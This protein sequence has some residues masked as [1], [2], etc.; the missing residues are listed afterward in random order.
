MGR[1]LDSFDRFDWASLLAGRDILLC[2][3]RHAE[4][5][6]I[7]EGLE[8]AGARVTI[9]EDE[10]QA[11]DRLERRQFVIAILA[12]DG[13]P[14]PR[15][16]AAIQEKGARLVM[17]AQV[18]RHAALRADFPGAELAERRGTQRAL[19]LFLTRTRDE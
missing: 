3:T 4:A 6:A 9:T 11:L 14:S 2:A 16:C 12:L 5:L 8:A 10:T 1:G 19:V 18:D 17:L 13:E 7:A 15:L